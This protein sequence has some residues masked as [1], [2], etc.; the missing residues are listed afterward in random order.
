ML[1]KITKKHMGAAGLVVALL[2]TTLP[3]IA[4]GQWTSYLSGVGTGFNSRSWIDNQSDS[5]ATKVT[6]SGCTMTTGGTFTSV[7]IRLYREAGW[8]PDQSVAVL[9]NYCGTSNFGSNLPADNYHFTIER[10]NGSTST[11]PRF[12][13]NVVVTTY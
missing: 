2:A 4:E 7:D 8:L 3:A 11:V 5:A 6:L 10:I 1:K 12:S 9:R 13:A